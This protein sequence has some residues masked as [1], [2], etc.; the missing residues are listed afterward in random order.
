MFG[1]E[2]LE[3]LA[4]PAQP[5]ELL[6]AVERQKRGTPCKPLS[7]RHGLEMNNGTLNYETRETSAY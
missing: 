2:H 5:P 6:L 3:R 7:P 4:M 1:A